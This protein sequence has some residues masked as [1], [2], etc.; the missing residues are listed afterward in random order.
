MVS[1]IKSPLNI[2]LITSLVPLRLCQCLCLELVPELC[3]LLIED[4]THHE[5]TVRVAAAEALSSALSQYKDQSSS[6]LSQLTEL[7]QHK[8]YVSKSRVTEFACSPRQ[9]RRF[10]PTNRRFQM[11]RECV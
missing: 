1:K 2:P 5:L 7:Y 6:V 4:V 3:P 10:P 9:V 11:I 8:L